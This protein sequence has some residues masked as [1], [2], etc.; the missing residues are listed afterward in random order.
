MARSRKTERASGDPVEDDTEEVAQERRRRTRD[1]VGTVAHVL[2]NRDRIVDDA[3]HLLESTGWLDAATRERAWGL[4]Q[5]G[6][7]RTRLA[8][9]ELV[10]R[11]IRVPLDKFE[12][13]EG[14]EEVDLDLDKIDQVDLERLKRLSLPTVDPERLSRRLRELDVERFLKDD[15]ED[16][17]LGVFSRLITETPVKIHKVRLQLLGVGVLL[18]LL[19]A[20]ALVFPAYAQLILFYGLLA[21]TALLGVYLIRWSLKIDRLF[22]DADLELGV[23]VKLRP[24]ERRLLILRRLWLR[25]VDTSKLADTL[26]HTLHTMVPDMFLDHDGP[27]PEEEREERLRRRAAQEAERADRREERQDRREARADDRAARK[28]AHGAGTTKGTA[29]P[30]G[31]ATKR[32]V[33]ARVKRP[34]RVDPEG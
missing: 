1:T 31:T 8:I 13:L 24:K 25:F 10:A 23:L 4:Y 28:A 20:A 29:A 2:R 3:L 26:E 30:R 18:L 11:T 9:Q 16:E 6:D 22:K 33:R 15:E 34:G 14:L 19:V 21:L 32:S 27:G 17:E 5:H 7:A 12:S